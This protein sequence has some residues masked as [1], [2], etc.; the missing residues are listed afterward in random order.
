MPLVSCDTCVV[1]GDL[2]AHRPCKAPAP[3]R[4]G[5]A[6]PAVS[7]AQLNDW[8]AHGANVD[9]ELSNAVLADDQMR[10]RYLLETRDYHGAPECKFG[11]EAK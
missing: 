11:C 4:P 10:V 2:P 9:T 8:L 1:S 5:R 6:A 3:A 7:I